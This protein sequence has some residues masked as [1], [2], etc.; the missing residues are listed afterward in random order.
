MEYIIYGAGGNGKKIHDALVS[1]GN[2]VKFFIDLYSNEGSYQGTKIYRIQEVT[3]TSTPLL[4]S[5]SC[6]GNDIK[7]DLINLGF[8]HC[9]NLNEILKQ[10]PSVFSAFFSKEYQQTLQKSENKYHKQ[11]N[12]LSDKL[13]DNQSVECLTRIRKFRSMPCPENYVGNDWQVQYFPA[14]LINKNLIQSPLRMVDC[15]AFTGD[16]LETTRKISHL[17][18]IN[19]ESMICFEPDPE[20]YEKLIK[21]IKNND[22]EN[23]RVVAIP[24]GVWKENTEL[25]FSLQADQS[26]AMIKSSE[27]SCRLQVLKI[28]DLCFGI[29]PNYIK[30]DVEGAEIEALI[31]SEECIR[32]L[33]PNLAI[34]VY[35]KPKHLWEIADLILHFN[36]SYDLYLRSHGNFCNEIIL[37]AINSKLA[38]THG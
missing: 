11:L 9:Y 13:S 20:N 8:S 21:F 30:M 28:D 1:T 34:S 23:T 15:G 25:S 32:T 3:P 6:L 38:N 16:T 18:D 35:H 29:K 14:E 26:S 10:F 22:L 31:G 37:Y 17:Y 2:R 33:K 4:V 24:A 27:N 12:K 19:F 5:L 7:T 36:P